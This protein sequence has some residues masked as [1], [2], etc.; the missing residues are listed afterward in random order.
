MLWSFVYQHRMQKPQN[1]N[2]FQS[3]WKVKRMPLNCVTKWRNIKTKSKQASKRRIESMLFP[4]C[5][6]IMIS[7]SAF[8]LKHTILVDDTNSFKKTVH[9]SKKYSKF[10]LKIKSIFRF[11]FYLIF[12]FNIASIRS[13]Y[14]VHK[15]ISEKWKSLSVN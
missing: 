11:I 10:T 14:A 3:V 9:A 13:R 7:W 2:P 5:Y 15:S 12:R 8:V 4:F 6:F 1:S